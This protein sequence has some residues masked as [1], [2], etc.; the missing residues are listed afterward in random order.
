MANHTFLIQASAPAPF[1]YDDNSPHVLAAAKN[2]IPIYWY[3]L[4][5]PSSM[6]PNSV[7]CND[8]STF[9][10]PCFV[11]PTSEARARCRNRK[12]ILERLTPSSHRS[13]LNAW[14]GFIE[15]IETPFLHVNTAEFCMMDD[16][17]EEHF[18]SCLESFDQPPESFGA[19][20]AWLE[21]LDMAQIDPDN[22]A[23][24]VVGHRLAGFQWSRPVPWNWKT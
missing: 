24:T 16:G 18:R 8:G 15:A 3:S 21:M 7:P 22:L 11:T 4:F 12:Q 5:E 2:C 10:Y 1:Q 9:T 17:Y 14:L 19:D 6:A 23:G 13:V 20:H